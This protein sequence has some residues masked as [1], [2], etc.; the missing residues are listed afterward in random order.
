MALISILPPLFWDSLVAELV[1]NPPTVQET[2]VQF[3]GWKDPLEKGQAKTP[4]C[5]GFPGGSADNEYACNVGELGSV[6]GLGRFPGEGNSYPLQ[7]AGLE[8]SMDC[9]VRGITKSRI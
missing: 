2:L 6:P 1:K 7:Y 8:N 4:V 5:L 3:L 9:I